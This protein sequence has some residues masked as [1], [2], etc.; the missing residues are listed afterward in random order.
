MFVM[1]EVYERYKQD[2]FIY[3]VSLTHNNILSEDLLSETFLS[4][5]K[6]LPNFKGKSSIKTW[7]F[8]IARHKWYDH[9]RREKKEVSFDHLAEHYLYEEGGLEEQV[10]QEEMSEK[11]YRLLGKESLRNKEIVLLRI[12]GYSFYE[13][14]KKHD[15][16]ES[17]ARVIDF[18][19]KKKLR[20]ILLKEEEDG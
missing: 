9:L 12:E 7:L 6:S 11:I 17:S 13:I 19:T 16:S 5:I 4:A 15:I 1:E 10:T 20:N 8:S 2:V 3:L 14:A 18:R